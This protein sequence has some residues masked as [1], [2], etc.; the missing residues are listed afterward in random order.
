MDGKYLCA[1]MKQSFFFLV[2]LCLL[3]GCS[4]VNNVI[5]NG[6]SDYKIY[7][8]DSASRPEQVAAVELQEYLFRI[9]GFRLPV[10]HEWNAQDKYVCVGFRDAPQSLLPDINPQEFGNEEYII[11][12]DGQHLLIAGGQPRG[13]LYGVIGYLSDHLGCRW[14]TKDV[15]KIPERKII[16][17]PNRDDRQQPAFEY[18]EAWYNEAYQPAWA[19]HNRLNPSIVPVPDSLG[20]S[21][22]SYPFVHTFYN[23]VS[24]E[25]YFRQHPEY[26]SEVNGKRVGRDAQLC[27]TNPEVV[28]IAT[29]TVLR[30]IREHPEASIFAVDQNDG[31]GYCEC[32]ACKALDDAEGSHAGTLLHFVNQ[33]AA[34]VAREYPNVKLQTLAYAYTEVP[35][36]TLRP[37]DNVTIRLCH[38][39]YC[40]AHKIG[41]C[42]DHKPFVERL[43]QW[44]AIA[45]RITVWDY[46]TDFNR[47]LMPFPNFEPVKHDV[48]FYADHQVKGLFAQGS[49]MPSEGGSEFSTLRAW[50]FAQLMWNPD[51]DAQ[52]LIDEFVNEVYGAAAPYIQEYIRLLHDQVKPDSVYFS[53]WSEPG[54]VNFLGAETI[55][56]ADSLFALAQ[57]VAKADDRLSKRIELAYLPVLY[58]KLYFHA[59][60]ESAYL[61]NEQAAEAVARFRRIVNENK[62]TRIAEG[63]DY[64]NVEA[65]LA[66]AEISQ[67]FYTDWWVIGPFDNE[68]GKGLVTVFPPEKSADL[69]A[70]IKGKN[71]A[72]LKWKQLDRRE[73]GY[74]DFLKIFDPSENVVAYARKTV[75]A[76]SAGM[77]KFGVG[78]NDGV[79]VWVNGR[80]VLDRQVARRARVNEDQISVPLRKGENDILVKVDQLKRGWGF[81][82]S[83]IQ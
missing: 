39:N 45:R 46:F 50:V 1:Y 7:V 63:E 76:D 64:G 75:V 33:V 9:T 15:V 69:S 60:G 83:E 6:R 68:N 74:I 66:G 13:T 40:S 18:R 71:G 47:Y 31:M 43:E 56:K 11:R 51:Q 37:A 28:N 59:M 54:E 2:L 41:G 49:N 34:H 52:A 80:L 16:P 20:G 26:F 65:F 44:R 82:F 24:P 30:W 70:V 78:S 81:Y 38:Y 19:M 61:S 79:R 73:S 17:L 8:S 58:T 3:Y 23:M 14:Y 35:P 10:T 27:L 53:I 22:I 55:S 57:Q 36:K 72:D 4:S 25:K 29:Q 62:I 48:K 32:K 77:V 12:S 67:H 5:V 21:Y 42:N